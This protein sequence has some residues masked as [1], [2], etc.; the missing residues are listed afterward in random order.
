[1]KKALL[2]CAAAIVLLLLAGLGVLMRSGRLVL[3]QA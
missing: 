3:G 1:M 2:I